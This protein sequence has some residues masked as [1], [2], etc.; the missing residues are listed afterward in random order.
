MLAI[1]TP[2]VNGFDL[3]IQQDVFGALHSKKPTP[4]AI[5]TTPKKDQWVR[6]NMVIL[7]VLR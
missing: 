7:A 3:V 6:K 2:Q 4:S 5:E 1:Q